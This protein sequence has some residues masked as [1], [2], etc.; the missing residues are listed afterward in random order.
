MRKALYQYLTANCESITDWYQPFAAT[1]DTQKPYGVI[2]FGENPQNA[3]NNRTSFQ[4]VSLWIYRAPGS[5][6]SIDEAV[7]EIKGLF[8]D[9]SSQNLI[10]G[11]KL[12]TTEKGRK[13]FLE[14]QQTGRDFYDDDLKAVAKKIDFTIPL[15]G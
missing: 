15:G 11:P 4:D 10:T 6:L 8:V 14:W 7:V 5:F 13:F 9:K 2:V 12:L 3:F 1:A